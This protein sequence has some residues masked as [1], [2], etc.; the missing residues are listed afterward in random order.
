M[1]A[2][3]DYSPLRA[4]LGLLAL[5]SA[6]LLAAA[7][8]AQYGFGLH[9]CHLCIL[10][11]YPY[12][13]VVALGLVGCVFVR[14]ERAVFGLV[15]LCGA[16][17][18]VDAGIATYHAGV[19]AGIFTGPSGCTSSDTGEQTLEEMRAAI[20]NAPLVTCDQAMAHI[21]GLSLAAWNALAAFAL[22]LGTF[23]GAWYARRRKG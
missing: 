23:A 3:R 12:A 15:L 1:L 16:L 22:A 6:G 20:M 21:L 14:P 7:L 4:L 11:R 2:L 5:A 19:E 10:Q 9:P 13:L 17:F 8:V 18:L